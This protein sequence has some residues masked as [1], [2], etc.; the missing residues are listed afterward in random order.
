MI[1]QVQEAAK[2]VGRGHNRGAVHRAAHARGRGDAGAGAQ[3]L[4][5]AEL[6]VARA[7]TLLPQ[8]L[9]LPIQKDIRS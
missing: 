2:S 5:A 1:S 6:G 7:R 4:Q 3:R 9:R 8:G